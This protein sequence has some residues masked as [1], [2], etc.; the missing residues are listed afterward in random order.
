MIIEAEPLKKMVQL[1]LQTAFLKPYVPVSLL[2]IAKPETGKTSV[3]TTSSYKKNFIF[4]TNEIT[5]KMLNDIVLPQIERKEIRFI[6]IP[7]ILNCIEKQKSTRQ[8][9][10]NFIKTLIEEGVTSTWT[11]HKR[12]V[13][14]EPLKCGLITAIT[15]VD[16][17]RVKRYLENIGLLSR[18]VPFSYD[19][20]IE[21][22]KK[23]F[24]HI[25]IEEENEDKLIMMVQRAKEVKGNPD[26]FKEFELISTKL[27]SQYSGYGFRAQVRLQQLAKANALLNKRTEVNREDIEEIVK[28][29]N[30]INFDFNPL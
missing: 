4:F 21:K 6:I 30:W 5:A 26:L 16:F 1:T 2:L 27:A 18:F 23:I 20:A 17:M 19:Y 12:Y 29:S 9:F 22:V 10:L 7:D 25:E 15:T 3:L 14:K 28:L 13:A 11:Y 24:Q 8:Q